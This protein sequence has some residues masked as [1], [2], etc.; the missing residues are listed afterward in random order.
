M[1]SEPHRIYWDSCV[2][3]S[4]IERTPSRDAM[5]WA[6][7]KAAEAGDLVLVASSLVIA[8]VIKIDDP[9][10]SAQDQAALIRR[11]FENDYIKIRAVDRRTAED[12]AEISRT[13]GLKPPDAIHVATAIRW[14]CEC[15][16]TYDGEQGGHNKLLAFDGRIGTP[17]LKIELPALPPKII[18]PGLPFGPSPEIG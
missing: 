16:Q 9:S 13:T 14:K 2:Y 17:P 1:P 15:L 10:R 6:I 12:A 4:C 7:A 8:E 5:L 18:Q 3:I 11:F